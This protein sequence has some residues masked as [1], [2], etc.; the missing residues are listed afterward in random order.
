MTNLCCYDLFATGSKES[1][2]QFALMVK[3]LT[4]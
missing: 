3:H 4:G 1:V 2:Q